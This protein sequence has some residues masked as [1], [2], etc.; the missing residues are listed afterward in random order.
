[1]S[2][3]RSSSPNANGAVRIAL[4][5]GGTGGHLFP[6][7]AVADAIQARRPDV[8]MLFYG[9]GRSIEQDHVGRHGYALQRTAAR[10]VPQSVFGWPRFVWANYGAYRYARRDLDRQGVKLV[11][12]LGG[13]AAAPVV[14]AA[15]ALGLPVVL[16]EQNAV[17]GRANRY[18][19]RWADL[20]VSAL[21]AARD[22]FPPGV[23]VEVLGNPLR[24]GFL[25]PG[26]SPGANRLH[27]R[28]GLDRDK[29][30]LVVVGGSQGAHNVNEAVVHIL[31]ELARHADTWQVLHQTGEADE[32]TVAQAYGGTR[33][34]HRVAG[35]VDDMPAAYGV[36]DLMVGRAGATTLAELACTGTPAVFLPLPWAA[37]DH[38][39]RNAQVYVGAGA[40]AIVVDQRDA[41]RTGPALWRALEPLLAHPERLTPMGE[42]ARTLGRP[43]AAERTAR[44]ILDLL[45]A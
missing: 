32:A 27:D 38:Q 10:P 19:A 9:T 3:G 45:P 20:V 42:A 18:L 44:A 25:A 21:D 8:R 31:P 15:A 16:L 6:G 12:G 22:A 39:T 26:D 43:D 5:G 33:L 40:G 37:E 29:H 28:L 1:M 30:T 41:T 14:R 34:K 24:G 13:Y 4:A 7:L 23:R 36:A 35:F 11:I 17:P 2:H